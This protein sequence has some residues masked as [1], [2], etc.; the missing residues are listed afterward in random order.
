MIISGYELKDTSYFVMDQFADIDKGAVCSICLE[1]L[2]PGN[3]VIV[4]HP[5]GGEKHPLHINCALSLLKGHRLCP[6]CRTQIN[7][8]QIKIVNIQDPSRLRYLLLYIAMIGTHLLLTESTAPY[9]TIH[10][11]YNPIYSCDVIVCKIFTSTVFISVGL[12]I[13]LAIRT[14]LM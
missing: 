11:K 2:F 1:P 8:R 3:E 7:F 12:I 10:S 13:F 4:A 14:L 5:N 6:D 9:M